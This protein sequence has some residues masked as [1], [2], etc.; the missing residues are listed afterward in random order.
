MDHPDFTWVDR[1]ISVTDFV[2]VKFFCGSYLKIIS[3]N[4]FTPTFKGFQCVLPRMAS[5]IVLT[6][7][8]TLLARLCVIWAIK[9]EKF[10]SAIRHGRVTDKKDRTAMKKAHVEKLSL[11]RHEPNFSWELAPRRIITYAK[12]HKWIFRGYD[13]TSGWVF[14]FS[15]P[16]SVKLRKKQE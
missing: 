10:G 15:L 13:F 12:V 3:Y 11:N 9:R 4:Y 2:I 14:D 6:P 8:R 1:I 16:R 7:K 5:T